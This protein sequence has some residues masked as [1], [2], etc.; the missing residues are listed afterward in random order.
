MIKSR[1]TDLLGIEYP[2]IQGGMVWISD[3]S[4]AAAVSNA[5]GL[6]ILG[7]GHM[8]PDQVHFNIE[9]MMENTDKPWGLNAPMLRPDTKQVNLQVLSMKYVPWPVYSKHSKKNT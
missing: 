1:L 7:S 6:G 9:K 3:W 2:V 4:L 5:G 8:N